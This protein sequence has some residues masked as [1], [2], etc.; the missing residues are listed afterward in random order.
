VRVEDKV[1]IIT[2]A[3]SGIGR[4]CS[5]LMAEEGAK[6]IASDVVAERVEE[7]AKLIQEKGGE[8]IAVTGDV[9]NADDIDRMIRAAVETSGRLDI[10]IN[11]A[12]ILLMKSLLET[13][14]DEWDRVQTINLKSV[15][16]FC[17]RAIPEMLKAGKGKIV[18][19]ASLAARL[20][21]PYQ[22]AYA[23]SKAGVVALT[24]AMAMEFAHQ[25]IGINCICPGAIRTNISIPADQVP[26]KVKMEGIPIGH[27]GEPEDIA[28]V[29]VFLASED[30]DYL[31]GEA[32]IVDGG[33]S[34]NLYPVYSSFTMH[35]DLQEKVKNGVRK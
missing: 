22:P 23:A 27:I 11:N 7:T 3:G 17:K 33:M 12:G 8:C 21:D 31:T 19:I 2:G 35:P 25:N 9:S 14:E 6:I 20:A 10:L 34:K 4:A 1:A 18:N 15:F 26:Y 24:Q 28:P 16:L 32:I 13:T 29:A 30:S 5:L